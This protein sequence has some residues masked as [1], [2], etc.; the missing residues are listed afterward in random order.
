MKM[1]IGDKIT[2]I[3]DLILNGNTGK[4]KQKC[5][6]EFNN[7]KFISLYV[8]ALM[9]EG[10][11]GE[12]EKICLN[13][14]KHIRL[15]SQYLSILLIKGDYETALEFCE[16]HNDLE[17]IQAQYIMVLSKYNDRDKINEIGKMYP[18]NKYVSKSYAISLS[19][20]GEYEDALKVCEKHI[21]DPEIADLYYEISSKLKSNDFDYEAY[22]EIIDLIEQNELLK[23][24]NICK[25]YLGARQIF[26]LYI[27][28]L[29]KERIMNREKSLVLKPKE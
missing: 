23:A 2:A 4:A 13:N 20:W 18:Y 28:I 14:I 1:Y 19:S 9:T 21:F 26:N 16:K 27:I 6:K 11:Y 7:P 3:N 12:A 15:M 29:E 25:R 17:E 24:K 8:K 5:L 22:Y 10:N